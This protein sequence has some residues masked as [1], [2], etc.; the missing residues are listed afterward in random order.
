M[1]KDFFTDDK[2]AHFIWAIDV[3]NPS[4]A[5]EILYLN[6]DSSTHIELF[7]NSKQ[8]RENTKAA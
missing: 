2:K 4:F 7:S 8:V 5:I 3:R 6:A 1:N